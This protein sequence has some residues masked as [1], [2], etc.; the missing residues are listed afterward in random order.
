MS[1]AC[2]AAWSDTA[3]RRRETLCL[4]RGKNC[5]TV[6]VVGELGTVL[7]SGPSCTVT[8]S[9]VPSPA[10]LT[11][12]V[13]NSDFDDS[14]E[15][16]SSVRVG[17]QSMSFLNN[18]RRADCGTTSRIMD[19]VLVPSSETSNYYRGESGVG[20]WGG[21]C[22]CPDGQEYNVGDNNNA[23]GSLACYGGTITEPCT[24]GSHGGG[25]AVTCGSGQLTVTIR[26]T[27]AVNLRCGSYYLYAEVR[28]IT[29]IGVAGATTC[30]RRRC[31]NSHPRRRLFPM[32]PR[33]T[34][35][36]RSPLNT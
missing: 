5:P 26:T 32:Y 2:S 31:C 21:V 28:L 24:S 16:I 35:G 10:W 23:C 19:S 6:L 1:A 7:C 22:T 13:Q 4:G 34:M 15:Y 25:M 36:T 11:V 3:A 27:S 33:M 12:D 8:F 29:S 14:S 30:I 18:Y 20:G 17:S 9:N